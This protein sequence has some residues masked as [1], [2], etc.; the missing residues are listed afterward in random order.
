MNVSLFI[1]D[2][3]HAC[4]GELILSGRAEPLCPSVF[5]WTVMLWYVSGLERDVEVGRCEVDLTLKVAALMLL[6][7]GGFR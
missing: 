4:T 5:S 3:T 7:P 2:W 6:A 1:E